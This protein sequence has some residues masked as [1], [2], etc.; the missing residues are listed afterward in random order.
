MAFNPMNCK[1]QDAGTM[2]EGCKWKGQG[3]N[4]SGIDLPVFN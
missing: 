4:H 2:N 1:M 3:R